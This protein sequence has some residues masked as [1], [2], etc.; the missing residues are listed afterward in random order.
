[1]CYAKVI[2]SNF[3]LQL[4]R[5]LDLGFHEETLIFQL[6]NFGILIQGKDAPSLGELLDGFILTNVLQK[7]GDVIT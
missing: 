6:E 5:C 4:P 1:V 2:C 7:V 3:S